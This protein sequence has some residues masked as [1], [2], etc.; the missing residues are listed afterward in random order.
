MAK[1]SK[2]PRPTEDAAIGRV[3]P[4]R[5]SLLGLY[6]ALAL[7][8]RRRDRAGARL[9]RHLLAQTAAGGRLGEA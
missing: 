7:A 4:R 3:K 2:I 8:V 5:P 9:V 1:T 6:E